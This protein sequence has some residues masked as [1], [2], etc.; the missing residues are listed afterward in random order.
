M[1]ED[2]S[3]CA[4]DSFG[5]LHG[6]EGLYI[7]DA[8]LL[9][10]PTVVNPQGTV[11]AVAHRN[12]VRFLDGVRPSSRAHQATTRERQTPAEAG[13]AFIDWLVSPEG[14]RAIAGYRL[15]GEQLFFPNA[16]ASREAG[17]TER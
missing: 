12:A 3:R 2:A 7:A 4:T 10:G 13:Q 5:K 11:M 14:Q 9:C 16:R 8:S 6:A 17:E 15:N 1:G